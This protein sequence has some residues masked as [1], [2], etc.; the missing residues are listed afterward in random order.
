M[1]SKRQITTK[2][3]S[4]AANN[5]NCVLPRRVWECNFGATI[6]GRE[7]ARRVTGCPAFAGNY[8]VFAE[9][10]PGVPAPGRKLGS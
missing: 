7:K 8:G 4:P 1:D 10:R 5:I 6:S 9:N 3:P 2:T